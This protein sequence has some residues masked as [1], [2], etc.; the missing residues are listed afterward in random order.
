MSQEPRNDRISL[1]A[2]NALRRLLAER[3]TGG[4]W[5]GELSSSALSTAVATAALE[6]LRRANAT[7]HKSD[8]AGLS[9][10][11]H[12]G[13]RWITQNQN[14][15]G[16]WGDTIESPSNLSTTTL[17]WAALALVE[18]DDASCN[19]AAQKAET[20]L[21]TR[22]GDSAQ[23]T[24]RTKLQTA[25]LAVA[26]RRAYGKDRTFSVPILTMCA[27]TER[28]GRGRAAW[29]DI[30]ALPFELAVLPHGLYKWLGL[31]VVSYA[32]PALVAIGQARHFH[33]PTR[34]PITRLL[35]HGARAKTLRVLEAMQPESGGFLEAAPLTGFVLMSLVSM[36]LRQHPVAMRATR[37]LVET[38]RSDGSWAID[39]NLATWVTTLSISALSGGGRLNEHLNA[40]ERDAL[41]EWLLKQQHRTE[42]PY[43]HA[44]PGGWAW[45]NL[46]GGV[47]DGDDTPGAL[48]ALR[49]LMDEAGGGDL[50][51]DNSAVENGIRWL[52]DLRNRDGGIPTFCRGWG[53][54]PFDRS[55]PDL[56]AHALRAWNAWR[57]C[58][59]R[60]LTEQI[61]SAIAKAILFLLREQRDDGAWIPLWFGNQHEPRHENPLYGTARVIL[62]ADVR[63]TDARMCGDW[64]EALHQAGKWILLSQ[65]ADGGWGGDAGM[66]SSIEE[67]ALALEA[68]ACLCD[69]SRDESPY[70]SNQQLIDSAE[71]ESAIT[72][73]T[74]CLADMTNR[75][76]EFLPA[77][78]GLY[79]AK[80]WYHERLYPLIFTVSALERLQ[81]R[82]S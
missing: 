64:H 19:E 72:R 68:L 21:S 57:G 46:S 47:P 6:M 2:A 25:D 45:T 78:I 65:N 82:R 3:V 41:R 36:G 77:P 55:C 44:A 39:T 52:L 54:L 9:A 70:A 60:E 62:A 56:T 38:V 24:P 48:L 58:V 5:I 79:F 50:R 35:R 15:D 22:L 16:G 23:N 37:F 75:G 40:E 42:H 66:Q 51:N 1:I 61:D 71:C 34:N 73:G 76:M 18:E 8:W 59:S 74:A 63:I 30:P 31:P 10:L 32:L 81:A 53:K 17:C 11:V 67:T 26:I 27:L 29:R 28:L 12:G 49:H 43:T 14:T 80:L 4:H 20:W 33:R 13:Y 69:S 7:E